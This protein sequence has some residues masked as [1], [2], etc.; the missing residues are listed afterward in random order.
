MLPFAMKFKDLYKLNV[1]AFLNEKA[2]AT[3]IGG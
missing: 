1:F 3:E 2:N